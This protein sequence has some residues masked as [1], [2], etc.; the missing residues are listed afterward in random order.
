MSRSAQVYLAERSTRRYELDALRAI[1]VS[2]VV[3]FHLEVDGFAFGYLGVDL[4]FVMSGYLMTRL[5]HQEGA[6]YGRVNPRRFLLK[7]F[8]RLAPS[9]SIVLLFTVLVSWV[10]FSP[11]HLAEVGM[12]ATRSTLMLSNLLF[13]DQAGYFEPS[14]DIRPLLHTW[15]LSVEEQFYLVFALVISVSRFVRL[16]L[17]LVVLFVIG[18]GLWFALWT[19]SLGLWSGHTTLGFLLVE[20]DSNSALFYLMPYRLVQ[21]MAGSML[22]LWHSRTPSS[23]RKLSGCGSMSIAFPLLALLLLAV[24]AIPAALPYS[25]PLATSAG[26]LLLMPNLPMA[27]LGQYPAVQFLAKISYQLYLVHWPLIV[28]WH[29]VTFK[30]LSL[31]EK[32]VL[33][34][35]SIALGWAL[36]RLTHSCT[37]PSVIRPVNTQHRAKRRMVM[38]LVLSTLVTAFTVG[39]LAIQTRGAPWRIPNEREA[40]SS[41]NLRAQESAYCGTSHLN[42]DRELGA[43][44]GDPLITCIANSDREQTIYTLGDSHARHLVPG[45]THHFPNHRIAAMY[46]SSCHPQ[47]GVGGYEYDYEGRE[48]LSKACVARNRAALDFFAGHRPTTIIIHQYDGYH[49]DRSSAFYVGAQALLDRL[50]IDYGHNVVW[51]GP[52]VRPGKLLADCLAVPGV[53]SNA[54]LTWRCQ[55]DETAA[56]SVREHS[57]VMAKRF[58]EVFVDTQ[59]FF[60]AGTQNLKNDIAQGACRITGDNGQILFRDK[61]HLSTTG[62]IEFVGAFRNRLGRALD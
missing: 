28:F 35:V 57:N 22:A 30:D 25:T 34:M 11:S 48:A 56:Q 37:A 8:W 10:L 53:Y 38:V 41:S 36:W 24:C 40:Q 23:L 20:E 18:L 13:F 17:V 32:S 16:G 60:C 14:N 44:P 50:I 26:L 42:G 21:F 49:S 43:T 5:V 61:H 27:R 54:F 29:Y 39:A 33:L 4:F 12:Q 62:S 45:L 19:Q 15:S 6:E 52:V 59:R 58:G 1:A 2:L 47:S 9:L 3:L 31:I 51:L 55:G 46:F 7:R